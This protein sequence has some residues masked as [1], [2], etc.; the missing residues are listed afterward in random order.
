M[1]PQCENVRGLGRNAS[2]RGLEKAANAIGLNREGLRTLSFHDLRHMGIDQNQTTSDRG[3]L[4]ALS[5][6]LKAAWLSR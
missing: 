1:L 2:A 4:Q 6:L 5:V 3:P